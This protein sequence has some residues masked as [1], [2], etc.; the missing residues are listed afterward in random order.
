MFGNIKKLQGTINKKNNRKK[1]DMTFSEK[2]GKREDSSL[3][4]SC[5]ETTVA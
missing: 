2:Q 3:V 5:R 4:V 1:S